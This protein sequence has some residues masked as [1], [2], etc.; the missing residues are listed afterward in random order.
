[1]VKVFSSY[2]AYDSAWYSV[3]L[4]K[5]KYTINYFQYQ[6]FA[7]V[8]SCGGDSFS[9]HGAYDFAWDTVKPMKG[10]YTINYIQYAQ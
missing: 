8:M 6:A 7:V 10:K 1:M 9:S 3:K 5:G 4:M 2:D